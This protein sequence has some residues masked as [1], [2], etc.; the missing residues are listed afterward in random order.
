MDAAVTTRAEDD[1][2][3]DGLSALPKGWVACKLEEIV[4]RLTDGTHQPPKIHIKRNS[5]GR[6][7]ECFSERALDRFRNV[8][9]I[10][11]EGPV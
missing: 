10:L 3:A 8:A 2:A 4:E 1:D 7:R 6:D 9:K 5:V 11:S